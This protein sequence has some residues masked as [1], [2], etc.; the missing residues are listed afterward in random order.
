MT[1]LRGTSAHAVLD[2]WFAMAL[3]E[4]I[5][6]AS[7]S[8]M[9]PSLA[10]APS[11]QPTDAAPRR[12][13]LE[14]LPARWP[15]ERRRPSLAGLGLAPASGAE[16]TLCPSLSSHVAAGGPTARHRPAQASAVSPALPGASRIQI[17]R[18]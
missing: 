8:Y 3:R 10:Q 7:H 14:A 9:R 16:G 6:T 12:D 2:K 15:L 11:D 4:R 1:I 18:P 5:G 17:H 13:G